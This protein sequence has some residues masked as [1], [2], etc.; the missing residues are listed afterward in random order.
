MAKSRSTRT[1]PRPPAATARAAALVE[2]QNEIIDLMA[3]DADLRETLTQIARMVERL[4]PHALC[5]VLLLQ[6]DGKHLRPGAAPSLPEAFTRATD[7]LEIGPKVGSCGTAA[8]RKTPVVVRDIATDPL[9]EGPRELALSFGL[10]ACWSQPV[11]DERGVVLGTIAMYYRRPRAP[12]RRDFGLLAPGARLV[13]L[14][15]AQNRKTEALR[16][17]ETRTRLA[18]EAADLGT[19]DVDLAAGT[20]T[21]SPRFKAMMGVAEDF[22]PMLDT[23]PN[24]IH[25]EERARFD[26]AFTRWADGDDIAIRGNEFRII[27]ADDGAERTIS[28]RGRMLKS[29]DGKP[30]RVTGIGADITEV[31]AAEAHQ[32]ETEEKIHHLHKMEALGQLAGGI[33]HDL[34]NTLMPIMGLSQLALQEISALDPLRESLELIHRAGERAR[35]LVGQILLF[36]R[37]EEIVRGPVKLAA[38]LLASRPLLRAII[39]ANI[40]LEIAIADEPRIWA[41]RGQIEQVIANLVA[42]AAQAIGGDPGTIRIEIASETVANTGA[43]MA[44]FSVVD[45]GPGI[46]P[47]ALNRLFEPFFTTKRVGEGTGLG[48]AMVHGIVVNH[49]GRVEAKS[50]IGEGARFDV[51]LPLFEPAIEPAQAFEEA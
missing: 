28:L 35:D 14:A 19:F 42:N 25:P 39:P 51:R 23:L 18:T 5:T 40:A 11:I 46:D 13:R 47:A 30:R 1:T 36:S 24:L 22:Q 4:A 15:L 9:W 29:A 3:S 27:R 44:R 16:A 6:P 8:W 10:R 31:C 26:G 20:V 48:L 7:G 37:K 41:N 32:R 50:R 38:V 33:A 21:W 49:G 34:N 43:R 2:A 12:T 17:A 45:D